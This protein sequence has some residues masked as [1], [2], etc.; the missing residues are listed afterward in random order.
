MRIHRHYERL[1]RR[2]IVGIFSGASA[3]DI[4]GRHIHLALLL[5]KGLAESAAELEPVEGESGDERRN[6]RRRLRTSF[7]ACL[8]VL[9]LL[10]LA[11]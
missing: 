7:V 6:R 9:T 10:M 8:V 1:R 5:L 11:S 2:G 4:A 3:A